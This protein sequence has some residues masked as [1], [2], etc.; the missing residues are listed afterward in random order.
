[1]TWRHADGPA[2]FAALLDRLRGFG[3]PDDLR[4]PAAVTARLARVLGGRPLLAPSPDDL[5]AIGKAL[6]AA[7]P[8][9]AIASE[10]VL[11]GLRAALTA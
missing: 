5:R 10:A 9:V 4:D 8:R 1:V 2:R 6:V 3:V 11:R 7:Q